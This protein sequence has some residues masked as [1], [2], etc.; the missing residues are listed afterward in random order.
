MEMPDT[1][2]TAG[3]RT[4]PTEWETTVGQFLAQSL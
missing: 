4:H 1:A 2:H 3:L